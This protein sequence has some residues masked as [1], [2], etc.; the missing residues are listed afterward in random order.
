MPLHDK[1]FP[2]E[3]SAY[4]SARDALLAEERALRAQ[5]E[6]VAAQRRALPR[7]GEIREDYMFEEE[8]GGSVRNTRLSELFGPR[9]TLIAYNYMFPGDGDPNK[10]CPMCTSMLDGLEGQAK[11]VTRQA[12]LAIIAKAPIDRLTA[13]ARD[14]GWRDLRLLSSAHNRYNADYHGEDAQSAQLPMMNVFTRSNGKVFHTWASELLFAPKDDGMQARHV[15]IV[16]P[17]WNVLD[18]TPE[19]RGT[20]WYPKLTY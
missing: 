19:G 16:W 14:R 13:F 18:M 17:L 5:V 8:T 6:R 15:D 20:G 11:H 7:G 9:N 10:P 3:S 1:R 4:R 12:S 2:N